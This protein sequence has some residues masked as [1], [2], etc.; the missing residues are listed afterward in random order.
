ME[1]VTDPLLCVR[2]SEGNFLLVNSRHDR[3][4]AIIFSVAN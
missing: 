1:R 4:P 3:M 2:K